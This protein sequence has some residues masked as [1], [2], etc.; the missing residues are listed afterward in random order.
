MSNKSLPGLFSSL[1][2]LRR[3]FGF[4]APTPSDSAPPADDASVDATLD[5]SSDAEP[6]DAVT[7][8]TEC[9]APVEAALEEWS[10]A[11]AVDSVT[12]ELACDAADEAPLDEVSDAEPLQPVTP[13]PVTRVAVEPQLRILLAEVDPAQ[14]MIAWLE[15]QGHSVSLVTDGQSALDAVDRESFDVVLIAIQIPVK[16]GYD[17]TRMVRERERKRAGRRVPMIALIADPMK[18][19]REICLEAGLDDCLP[20]P[21]RTQALQSMLKSLPSSIFRRAECA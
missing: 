9:D 6:V 13:E 11:E 12:A 17:V 2:G 7:P 1:S 20:K 15:E 14:S 18:G 19:D 3:R 4:S 21:V 16:N 5:E 8:E 10:D